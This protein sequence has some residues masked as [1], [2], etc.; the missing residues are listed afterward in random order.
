MTHFRMNG[1]EMN[2]VATRTVSHPELQFPPLQYV[3]GD[4]AVDEVEIGSMGRLYTYTVVH[5]GKGTEPYMLAMVDFEPG[6]RAF[7]RL[8]GALQPAPVLDGMV[9]VVPFNL[10]DGSPDYAFEPVQGPTA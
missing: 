7:G 8:T 10:A 4:E 5:P 1:H 9:R 3:N 2:L 6:V